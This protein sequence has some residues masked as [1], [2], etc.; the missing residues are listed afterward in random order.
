M[1]APSSSLF[2]EI[3]LQ[4]I[5]VTKIVHI[6]LQYHIIGY[7]RCVDN[8]LIAY[9]QNLTNI[10]EI[11]ACFNKLTPMLKIT[12]KKETNKKINF[13]EISITRNDNFLSFSIYTIIPNDSCHPPEHKVAAI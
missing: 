10:H 11:L 12:I 6:L 2:S 7:F 5:E 1:G 4:H 3:F 9:K 13:L 8:I